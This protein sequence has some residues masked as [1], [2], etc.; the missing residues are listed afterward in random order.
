[1]PV[2]STGEE[3]EGDPIML[4][5]SIRMQLEARIFNYARVWSIMFGA[6]E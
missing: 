2:N 4:S 1:M 3:G 5:P 6:W